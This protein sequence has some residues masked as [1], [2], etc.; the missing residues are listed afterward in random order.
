MNARKEFDV[1]GYVERVRIGPCFICEILKRNPEYAHH[2]VVENETSIVF[3]NKYPTLYGYL[4]VAPKEHRTQVTA[5][6]ALKE[7][8]DLQYLVYRCAEALR[9]EVPTERIYLLSLGSNQG[10]AH[11]H[12][13][14]APLPPNIPYEQQQFHALMGEHGIL[15][16][17]DEAM[18]SLAS[19][20]RKRLEESGRG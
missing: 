7:Y 4:L 6:F 13:H 20:L 8:L 1:T 10:N 15:E 5:D 9:V 17:P 12:W 11:V 2:V 14:I 16:I 3:L 18:A 19:R